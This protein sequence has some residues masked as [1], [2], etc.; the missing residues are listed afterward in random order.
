[1]LSFVCRENSWA[2]LHMHAKEMFA[3]VIVFI[4]FVVTYG[5]IVIGVSVENCCNNIAKEIHGLLN[6]IC[7]EIMSTLNSPDCNDNSM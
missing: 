5:C 4:C 3:F 7:K 6:R 2:T 1:M